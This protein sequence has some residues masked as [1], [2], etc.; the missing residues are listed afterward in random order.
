MA[1]V[2]PSIL[3]RP[4]HPLGD[5][6]LVASQPRSPAW[7]PKS[8][9]ATPL[10]AWYDPSDITT[11]FTDTAGTTPVTASG[12][13]VALIKDKSGNG[14]HASQA[15]AGSRP[16]YQAGSGNPYLDCSGGR[17]LSTPILTL[18]DGSGQHSAAAACYFNSVASVQQVLN[19]DNIGNSTRVSQLLR[20]NSTTPETI[21]FLGSGGN[22]TDTGPTVAVSTGVVLSEKT[23]TAAT[24]IFVNGVGDGSFALSGTLQ[25]GQ[26]GLQ[27][28][29][30]D[31][32]FYGS[33][34]YQGV[35]S[36]ADHSSLVSFLTAKLP[37]VDV[38][39]ALTGQALTTAL[40]SLLAETALALTGGALTVS[41]GSVAP[42]TSLA[43]SGQSLSVA[44]GSVSGSVTIAL[45]G[46]SLSVAQGTLTPGI[47]E[48]LSGQALTVAQGSVA[49]T[50]T[51]ALSGQGLSVAGGSVTPATS[52]A[53]VGQSASVA[54]GSVSPTSSVA[55]TGQGITATVG[56]LFA[57]SSLAL[58][59][60]S[61][62]VALG[63]VTVVSSDVTANLTGHGLSLG[64]GIIIATAVNGPP[65]LQD[66]HVNAENLVDEPLPIAGSLNLITEHGGQIVNAP[67]YPAADLA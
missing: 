28:G 51:P 13:T 35:L 34:N 15:T 26:T 49:P 58:T 31:G 62:V 11:L 1:L 53:L 59:G 54:Q 66:I 43:L 67:P 40:G 50:T 18:T 4:I 22:F 27:I 48:A 36:D 12:D 45:T 19:A 52:P 64:L 16:I 24:E 37:S 8:I 3:R 60:Q 55:I 17:S 41:Q 42:Q 39:V 56:T 30:I 14:N 29:A 61:L 47:S 33:A 10:V 2:L 6:S 21:A 65:Q 46:Q 32:R 57:S 5:T 44:Q 25:S 63:N 9:T 7:T 38:T 20:L 23:S